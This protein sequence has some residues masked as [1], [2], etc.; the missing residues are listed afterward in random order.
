ML[1]PEANVSLT[2]AVAWLNSTKQATENTSS[3][4]AVFMVSLSGVS[5]F[6]RAAA[7]PLFRDKPAGR[8]AALAA[9]A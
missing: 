4:Q 1:T 9:L 6:W 5:T 3:R 2:F 8:E 7:V